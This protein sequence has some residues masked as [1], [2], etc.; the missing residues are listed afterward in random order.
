MRLIILIVK[1]LNWPKF[2]YSLYFL[3]VFIQLIFLSIYTLVSAI[4]LILLKLFFLL[5]E[6]HTDQHNKLGYIIEAT[7]TKLP[8]LK[9]IVDA[10]LN[11]E[12]WCRFRME[13][14]FSLHESVCMMIWV[15]V[16]ICMYVFTYV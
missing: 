2:C 1:L 11:F 14:S 13:Q 3:I 5:I 12:C 10:I 4:D 15:C 9:Q 6:M 16:C 8:N 7:H